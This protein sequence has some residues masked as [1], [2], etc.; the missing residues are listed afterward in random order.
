MMDLESF[1]FLHRILESNISPIV[2][3]ATNRGF[4]TVRGS[5]IKSPHGIPSDL[6]DRMTIINT[7]LYNG[8]Q[9]S[10]II[11]LRASAESLVIQPNVL[12]HLTSIA[13]EVSMR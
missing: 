5:D 8:E 4:C 3:L 7:N 1:T 6:L 2:I 10:K 13:Q 12:A 9:I 11:G